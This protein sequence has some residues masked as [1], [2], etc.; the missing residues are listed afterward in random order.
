MCNGLLGRGDDLQPSFLGRAFGLGRIGCLA[1]CA[2]GIC[3]EGNVPARE[4]H[5]NAIAALFR[6]DVGPKAAR[7]EGY[8]DAMAIAYAR[9]P[10]DETK[11]FYGLAILGT[12]RE[13]TKGFERQAQ[14]AKLF[15]EVYALVQT[16]PACCTI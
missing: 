14:A 8:R 4:A 12:I 2:K 10:D 5:L 9:F 15:E 7:D 1:F 3:R 6:D 11:L 13:G 16:T